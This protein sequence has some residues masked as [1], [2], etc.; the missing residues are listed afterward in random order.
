MVMNELIE[1][2]YFEYSGRNAIQKIMNK[3]KEFLNE[4]KSFQRLDKISEGFNEYFTSVGDQLQKKI[5]P[6]NKKF[7]EYLSAREENVLKFR[8][9]S[10]E[11]V[12][13]IIRKIKNKNSHGQDL[14]TNKMIKFCFPGIIGT[15]TY[16]INKSLKN[17]I[18][19]RPLKSSRVVPIYKEGE[20]NDFSNY[21]D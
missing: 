21:T 6:S 3:V 13:K 16:L 9:V 10:E 17:G 18:V 19:P 4:D 8:T 14:L 2:I 1:N 11:T 12:L 15:I 5:K 20:R 7:N